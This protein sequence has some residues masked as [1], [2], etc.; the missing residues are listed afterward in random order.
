[1]SVLMGGGFLLY[2]LLRGAL[3]KQYARSWKLRFTTDDV[4]GAE[5]LG[6]L[7]TRMVRL[8]SLKGDRW[9][10]FR[11]RKQVDVE[12]KELVRKFG[13][14]A[15]DEG[16]SRLAESTSAL[17]VRARRPGTL[18]SPNDQWDGPYTPTNHRGLEVYRLPAPRSRPQ[19]KTLYAWLE[20]KNW[21]PVYMMTIWVLALA[22]LGA[23]VW[24]A[25]AR[26]FIF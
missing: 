25:T 7:A 23:W 9:S 18:T 15:A 13:E 10:W 26:C 3:F 6:S 5:D 16:V 14:D 12:A 11:W 24:F 20:A 2:V 21:S 19:E 1:M 22:G 17:R 4:L 8:R